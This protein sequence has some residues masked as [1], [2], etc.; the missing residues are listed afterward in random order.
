[1]SEIVVTKM[2]INNFSKFLSD[3]GVPKEGRDSASENKEPFYLSRLSGSRISIETATIIHKQNW[4][5]AKKVID[6]YPFFYNAETGW[7]L[8]DENDVLNMF[9]V[10]FRSFMKRIIATGVKPVLVLEGTSPSM[11]SRTAKKR[12]EA[13]ASNTEKAN[14]L[15]KQMCLETY[16]KSLIHLYPPR[17][18]HMHIVSEIGKELNLP[19]L[20]AKYEA[21]GVCAHLVMDKN[22]PFHCICAYCEDY[23]IFMYGCRAVISTLRSTGKNFE[24]TAYSIHDILQCMEFIDSS[25]PHN[26]RDPKH[27]SQIHSAIRRL[28][29][30]CILCGS[31][32]G[33]DSSGLGDKNNVPGFG[34]K[35]IWKLML[36]HGVQSY[37]EIC[38][39]EPLFKLIQYHDILDT[40]SENTKYT[41]VHTGN[42]S[43]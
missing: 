18:A 7:S 13:R 23:D 15:R 33:S 6:E 3:I 11:K 26:T 10:Y 4:A 16:K 32:Y 39:I 14:S 12:T 29:L 35:K 36:K 21:E 2:T 28:R 20:R 43:P 8:P 34:P 1:M 38:E 37:E 31:D 22:D 41:V 17:P 42:I 9:K 5:A 40:L 30:F 19:V 24:I 25:I 27:I